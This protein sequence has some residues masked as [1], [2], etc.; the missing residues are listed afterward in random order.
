MNNRPIYCES[1]DYKVC[2]ILPVT[3]VITGVGVLIFSVNRSRIG[4]GFYNFGAGLE[5][6]SQKRDSGHLAFFMR[7]S[8]STSITDKEVAEP[9]GQ[10]PPLFFRGALGALIHSFI[11]TILPLHECI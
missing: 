1:F 4:V 6:E 2:E 7:L 5:S 9:G 11:S 10:V 8:L 3:G